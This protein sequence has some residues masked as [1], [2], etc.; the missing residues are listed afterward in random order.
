MLIELFWMTSMATERGNGIHRVN[1][2]LIGIIDALI[3]FHAFTWNNS[4]GYFFWKEK[5]TCFKLLSS[6][7][8]FK[9]AFSSF[10]LSWDLTDDIF[11]QLQSL[12]LYLYRMKKAVDIDP[13]SVAHYKMFKKKFDNEKV[14]IGT[15][16]PCQLVLH[17]HCETTHSLSA[18]W[19]RATT[20]LI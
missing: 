6:S 11:Y 20:N 17:L 3:G 10:R 18:F 13:V 12:V 4:I 8:K 5:N 16:P 15:L 7:F 14:L 1:W 19:K 9:S 2:I